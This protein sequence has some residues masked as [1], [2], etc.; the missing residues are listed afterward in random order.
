MAAVSALGYDAYMTAIEA[1]KTAGSADPTAVND[2][3]WNVKYAGVTGD[4]SFDKNGDAIR[5]EAY[6]K[7]ANNS[8]GTWKFVGIQGV[9]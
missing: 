4:I 8:D 7:Q 9:N 6:I 5:E 2:A 1:V 3:L